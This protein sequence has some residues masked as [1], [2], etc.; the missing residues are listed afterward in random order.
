M[1][2]PSPAGRPFRR[3]YRDRDDRVVAGVAAG[4][5]EHLRVSP[6]VV[7]V[8]FIGLLFGSGF[9]ALLYVAFWAVLPVRP[10]AGEGEPPRR[11]NGL[12]RAALVALALGAVALQFQLRPSFSVDSALVAL[13]VVV[14]L[15]A[16]V[17]WHQTDPLRR[18]AAATDPGVSGAAERL[19]V[20]ALVEEP[21][22]R[23][24]FLLRVAGGGLLIIVGIVGIL[25]F[26][27]PGRITLSTMA[28]GLLFALIA[29]VG[30]VLAM[31]PILWRI[32]GQLR[33]ERVARI[34]EQ[35]RAE[36]AAIVH[37]Q[38][39]HTL[40]LIQRSATDPSSVMRLARG[41]ERS[42]RG[43]LY[44]PVGSPNERFAAALEQ[45][46][47]E[48][49]N[50]YGLNVETVVVGDAGHDERVA[51]VVA[52]TRE[53][54]VNAARH[55]GVS[56]VSLY[57][58]VEGDALTVFVRD[59]GAGF[60]MSTIDSDRHGISGSII[61]RMQRH[62]GMARIRSTPG[63]GTEVE[64]SIRLVTPAVPGEAAGAGP[65]TVT[66]PGE[67]GLGNTGRQ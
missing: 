38:V 17:I 46:A 29:L 34:R 58:E 62:G 43:W 50:A 16:G 53:A 66:V 33:E 67:P 39:L 59:R 7:R 21:P 42:L 23:R 25:G 2:R 40:A 51:A 32:M 49:E 47:A 9:G 27:A 30:L 11:S 48:V 5:A 19:R 15:G 52:A 57:A 64:L 18:R 65:Q 37:D 54:L 61:G 13:A 3:L 28:V 24:W 35:E 36:V 12:Q 44:G 4:I 45:V 31:A 55:A 56:T 10:P 20:A 22:D 1:N 26:L 14:A 60:E 63:E 6:L 41:Q 8:I